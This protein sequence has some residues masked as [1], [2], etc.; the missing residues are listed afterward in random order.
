MTDDVPVPLPYFLMGKIRR[1]IITGRYP[2]GS[3]LREQTL[4]TE[5]GTSR[6]PLREAMRLLQLK[7]LVTH[8]PRRGFKVR[9]YSA[10]LTEQIYRLRG[11]LE[12]HSIEALAGKALGGLIVELRRANAAMAACFAARDIEG[13]L[14]ANVAFHE[15]VLRT[16]DNEPLRK[17]L[18][19]LNEMAQP[20]RFA[21]LTSRFEKSTA[22]VEHDAIIDLLETGDLARAAELV[23]RHVVGNVASAAQLYPPADARG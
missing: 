9:D 8:E 16:A 17:S 20:I 2:P 18:E 7:G 6:G 11:L 1:G 4:E 13:Y 22:I 19:V 5:Y 3:A 21:L 23:E 14:E 15:A 12:R 10:E